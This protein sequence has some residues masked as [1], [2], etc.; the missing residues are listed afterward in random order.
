MQNWQK[1]R[2]KLSEKNGK[3]NGEVRE[4]VGK[5]FCY[6]CELNE[7]SAIH[8]DVTSSASGFKCQQYGDD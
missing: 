2:K 8:F 6:D 5:A 7:S 3:R 1:K 4:N